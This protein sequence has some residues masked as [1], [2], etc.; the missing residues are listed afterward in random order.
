MKRLVSYASSRD[1]SASC[2]RLGSGRLGLRR[3]ERNGNPLESRHEHLVRHRHRHR[4]LPRGSALILRFKAARRFIGTTL[5]D[6]RK[7]HADNHLKG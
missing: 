4:R 2:G 5:R 1:R 3:S 7:E 6:V